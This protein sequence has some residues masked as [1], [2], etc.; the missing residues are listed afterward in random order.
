MKTI[1][2]VARIE[3]LADVLLY[4]GESGFVAQTGQVG[5]ASG[6]KIVHA[7]HMMTLGNKC[8]AQMRAEEAGGAGDQDTLS[9][10][11]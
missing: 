2:D 5:G 8:V 1:I 10:Q 6:G 9:R 4:Q 3:R 11:R 7:H